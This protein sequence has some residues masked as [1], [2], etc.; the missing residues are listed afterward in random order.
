MSEQ[1]IIALLGRRDEPTDG[2]EE[3]CRFLGAALKPHGFA[4]TIFR[5]LW[6]DKG[7]RA[8]REELRAASREWR[9]SW[10]LLQYT[11]LAW[12]N[13]GFPSGAQR[14][15]R[16]ARAS[17]ART[18]VVF[19]DAHAH[20][21]TRLI[22]AIRRWAQIRMMRGLFEAADRVILTLPAEKIAWLPRAKE[23]AA[24]IPVGANL[25]ALPHEASQS[26]DS[27]GPL[28][29]AVFTLTGG[30][31]LLREADE[32]AFAVNHAAARVGKLR[33]LVCGRN[34]ADA[35]EPLTQ[36]LD[37]SRVALESHGVLPPEEVARTLA[38]A[39]VF[40]FIRGQITSRRGSA[41]AGIACGLPIVAYRGAETAP[42]V[43]EAGVVLVEEG[44]R[45]GLAANLERVLADSALRHSL[46]ERSRSAYEKHFSWPAIAARYVEVL[47][48]DS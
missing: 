19:H 30:A 9:D 13:R 2:V 5:V 32:I 16:I 34:A 1:R 10:I 43:T 33:L 28:T 20:P 4:L 25:P 24:F 35:R 22:D 36:R 12:S 31:H 46:R 27:A 8:A 41:L 26:T 47:R 44:D 45:E 39:D 6:A 3:Y 18:A 37:A 29:V 23:K 15:F 42:P 14:V 21:G 17:G 48:R 11:A 38:K 40:L 7:W